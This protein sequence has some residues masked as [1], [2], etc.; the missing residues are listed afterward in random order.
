MHGGSSRGSM[1][2]RLHDYLTIEFNNNNNNMYFLMF[3][4]SIIYF[5]KNMF[6]FSLSQVRA[7]WCRSMLSIRGGLGA[8]RRR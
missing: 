4:F 1:V 6:V 3:I 7:K 5:F 8:R 2:A